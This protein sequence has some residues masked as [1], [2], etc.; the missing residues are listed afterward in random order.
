MNVGNRIN[1]LRKNAG[2]TQEELAEKLDI[3][4]QSVAKWE[5]GESV[6]DI[7]R[8][9][10]LS[11]FFGIS[12]DFIL[13]GRNEYSKYDI[14]PANDPDGTRLFLCTAKKN[15]YAAHGPEIESSRP[16]SHDLKYEDGK[17]LYL[18]SYF[19]GEKFTGEEALYVE[20]KPF[21]A[22]NY[23]GRVLDSNFSGDFLSKCLS[24]VKP[25]KPFRGPDVFQDGNFSYYCKV[26]GGFDWFAG[27]EEIFF[28][29]VKVYECVFHGGLIK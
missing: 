19:G 7:D 17:Y 27:E 18:D 13:K 22:M 11:G 14:T 6:P 24:A 23:T 29:T 3:S 26:K 21:W 8:L 28:Q 9:I 12:T 1:E 25:E 15:T 16:H 2:L 20:K 5:N 10:A 4:R